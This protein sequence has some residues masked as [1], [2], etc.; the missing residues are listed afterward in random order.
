[1]QLHQL[2]EQVNQVYFGILLAEKQQKVIGVLIENLHAQLQSIKSKV[3]NGVLL[4][5]QQYALHAELIKARQ[6]SINVHSNILSGYEVLGEIIG[7]E[8][9]AGTPLKIPDVHLTYLNDE[10]L[11]QLRPEFSLFESNRLALDYQKKLAGAKKLPSLSAFGN[12]AY[13][14]PGF[15]VFENDLHPF[16][17]IGLRLQWNFWDWNKAG[18]HQQ[19][20]ELQQQS[21]TREQQAFKWQL[22]ANLSEIKNQIQALR[23]QLEWDKEIISLREKVVGQ[24]SSRLKNGAAT[25]T[26]YITE[27]NKATQA[28]LSMLM[29]EIEL[30]KAKVKYQ[31]V[32]GIADQK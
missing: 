14:R 3:A 26:E 4:A 15:N 6:D 12:A 18:T 17:M 24:L 8:V 13:G 7:K 31:T 16:Y 10:L 2:K 23:E 21:I 30:S 32:L 20:L 28:R 19:I 29:H 1:V 11:P 5:S 22:Q 9:V 27:L 25:A